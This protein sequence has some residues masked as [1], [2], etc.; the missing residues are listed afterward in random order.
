MA[1]NATVKHN[2]LRYWF[3]FESYFL[4]HCASL[5]RSNSEVSLSST[6]ELPPFTNLHN[7]TMHVCV[8]DHCLWLYFH[9]SVLMIIEGK[10]SGYGPLFKY[11]LNPIRYVLVAPLTSQKRWSRPRPPST[12]PAALSYQK[13]RQCLRRFRALRL[14]GAHLVGVLFDDL[15]LRVFGLSVRTIETCRRE[16]GCWWIGE[17]IYYDQNRVEP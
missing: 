14:R 1:Q 17:S 4:L 15:L 3:R 7:K 12:P 2:Y 10:F 13:N 11:A 8:R 6:T 9:H 5:F 16:R